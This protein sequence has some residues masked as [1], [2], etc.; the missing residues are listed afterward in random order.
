MAPSADQYSDNMAYLQRLAE[1]GQL[2]SD[3]RILQGLQ[4]KRNVTEVAH[5]LDSIASSIKRA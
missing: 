2:C 1:R 3:N 5:F 4:G